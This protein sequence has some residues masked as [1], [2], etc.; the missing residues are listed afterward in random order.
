MCNSN[1]NCKYHYSY[2]DCNTC[3]LYYTTKYH[4]KYKYCSHNCCCDKE[5]HPY[6]HSPC[7]GYKYG[8]CKYCDDY[9]NYFYYYKY[10]L[11]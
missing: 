1:C 5:H 10:Y 3:K 4:P 7:D 9:Y 6:Y 2:C 11:Y 8:Y